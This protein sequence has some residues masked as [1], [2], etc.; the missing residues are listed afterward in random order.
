MNPEHQLSLYVVVDLL[1]QDCEQC[2]KGHYEETSIYND[3]DGILHCSNC[4]QE[5][6]RYN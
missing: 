6:K 4:N 1:N 2:G 5:V 3:W